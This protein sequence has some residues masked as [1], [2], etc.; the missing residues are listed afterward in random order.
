VEVYTIE[1]DD[2]HGFV[3]FMKVVN[4]SVIQGHTIE[5]KKGM[6]ES[7]KELLELGIAEIKALFNTKSKEILVNT[8]Q[9][10]LRKNQKL[11]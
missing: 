8:T 11:V 10:S 5:M 4:G 6:E 2:S 1:T 3:N 7:S 9:V